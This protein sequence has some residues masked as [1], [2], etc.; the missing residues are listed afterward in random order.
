MKQSWDLEAG[1]HLSSLFAL[2]TDR[3]VPPG[4]KPSQATVPS[5][6]PVLLGSPLHTIQ[7]GDPAPSPA[8]VVSAQHGQT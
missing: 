7:A 8:P 3:G 6:G 2:P 5:L 1:N 4:Q